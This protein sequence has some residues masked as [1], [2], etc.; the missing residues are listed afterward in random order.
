MMMTADGCGIGTS[1]VGNT[2]VTVTVADSSPAG[3]PN[4]TS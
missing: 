1:G 2:L 4:W 3:P